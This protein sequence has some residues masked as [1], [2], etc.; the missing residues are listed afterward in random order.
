MALFKKRPKASYVP[1]S[2]PQYGAMPM[3]DMSL[4][5]GDQD[6]AV[7]KTLLESA[8]Q[9][10]KSLLEGTLPQPP[11]LQQLNNK[12]LPVLLQGSTDE[13][14]PRAMAMATAGGF[15]VGYMEENGGG[16]VPEQANGHYWNALV[17]LWNELSNAAPPDLGPQFDYALA[18]AYFVA[19][20]GE[21]AIGTVVAGVP[22]A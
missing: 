20:Q 8:E 7:T 1:L 9:N 2:P 14:A 10:T 12:L 17:M 21:A 16:A 15:A 4:M 6:K 19:R 11:V 22:S 13:R 3:P 18:A 5:T